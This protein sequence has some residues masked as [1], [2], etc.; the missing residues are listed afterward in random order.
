M[1]RKILFALLALALAGSAVAQSSPSFTTG[2]VP[3]AA[4][5]NG[6]FA[7][8]Q[9]YNPS[10]F[11]GA[12]TWT[13][14]QVFTAPAIQLPLLTQFGG[15]TSSFPALKRNG[16]VLQLRLADDS[17]DASLTVQSVTTILVIKTTAYPVAGLPSASAN[18]PGS[19]SFVNDATA[20][21]FNSI[22]AGGGSNLVPVFSDGTN[23][24]I[25]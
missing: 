5:W 10:F 17:G 22:V 14:G 4:Q 15:T 23:W 24:R 9:D 16:N 13:G 8:K 3:S 21:T 20:T 12:Y 6:Y 2:Q 11:A 7:G 25:G 1:I 19:R 18:G